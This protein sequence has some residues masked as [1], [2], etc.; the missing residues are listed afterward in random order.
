MENLENV[1]KLYF[2]KNG[3]DVQQEI[4]QYMSLEYFLCLLECKQ[5]YVS[6]KFKFVDRREKKLPIKQMFKL[7]A[8]KMDDGNSYLTEPTEEQLRE[9]MSDLDK[10]LRQYNS[11]S[12][13]PTSCWTK[14]VNESAVLW[15]HFTPR[16]GVC[17]HST[18]DDLVS[19]L[20]VDSEDIVCYEMQYKGY[21]SS[22]NAIQG[23][24]VKERY[25]ELEQEIRFY[26][27][28]YKHRPQ[29]N[30]MS[31]YIQVPVNLD[32]MID[33]VV[34]SPDIPSLAAKNLCSWFKEKYGIKTVPSK[35][36]Y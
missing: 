27:T 11:L 23:L 4:C 15:N 21:N 7:Y 18:I 10:K 20:E 1:S 22:L 16:M 13:L 36:E 14:Y 25:Y 9:D 35:I 2:L 12:Y 26:F 31:P 29:G 3:L 30:D 28:S 34:L 6:R 8:A 33:K 17:V 5:Y 24:C 19:S 32:K